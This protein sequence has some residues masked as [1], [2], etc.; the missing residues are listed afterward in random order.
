MRD[1]LLPLAAAG[2]FFAALTQDEFTF[3]E[4]MVEKWGIGLV[5]LGLFAYLAIWTKR[6]EEKLQ[7]ERV[8]RE[9]RS[10]AERVSLL[11]KNNNLQQE[12]IE[13]MNSH[14]AR[15][16]QLIEASIKANNEHANAIRTLISRMKRPCVLPEGD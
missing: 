13:S 11:E 4:R 8:A 1:L 14:G 12:L 15:N 6:R 10:H 3:W 5:G 2:P 7:E 16:E 9:E